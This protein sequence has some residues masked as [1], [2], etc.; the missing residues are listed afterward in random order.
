MDLLLRLSGAIDKINARFGWIATWMVILACLISAGNA[1]VRYTINYSSNGLLEVQWYMFGIMVMLGAPYTMKVNEHVRVDIIYAMLP[2]RG[3][4]LLDLIF[5]ITFMLPAIMILC[6]SSW[7]IFYNSFIINETS[8]NAG[9]L[10]RWPLKFFL[11]FGFF[12]LSLQ[13]LSEIIKRTGALRGYA[14]DL[15]QYKAPDQ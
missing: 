12:L 1:F 9:G 7:A 15:P 13:G 10:L 5:T 3:K 8:M 6:V 11:P 4:L 14:V 2:S